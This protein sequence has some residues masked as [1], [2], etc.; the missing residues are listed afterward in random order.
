MKKLNSAQRKALENMF[1]YRLPMLRMELGKKST[2]VVGKFFDGVR[3]VL[4]VRP[5]QYASLKCHCANK[6]DMRLRYLT[7][8]V[9][10][11]SGA[12]NYAEDRLPFTTEDFCEENIVPHAREVLWCP[13]PPVVPQ[14]IVN[15]PDP[16]AVQAM[17]ELL[18]KNAWV[19]TREDFVDCLETI[20]KNGLAS[21]L[22]VTKNG[23]QLNI[24]TITPKMEARLWDYLEGRPNAY[25]TLIG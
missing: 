21:S 16:Q 14:E 3:A 5:D 9:K 23:G 4:N 17:L 1:L 7:Y 15:L 8:E 10:V 24:Q 18:L 12:V 2:G 11:G 6:A 19:L 22:H 25:Q 13:L 20:G